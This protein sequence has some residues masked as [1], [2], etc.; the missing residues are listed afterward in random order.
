MPETKAPPLLDPEFL[1]KLEQLELVSRKIFVGRMKGERK[2]K[3]RGSS[4]E[5]AE[6]VTRRSSLAIEMDEVPVT[7]QGP[8]DGLSLRDADIGRRTGVM[9]IAVKRADGRVEFPPSGDEPFAAGDTAVLLGRRSNL[10]LFRSSFQTLT[11]AFA[12]ENR[13]PPIPAGRR[14]GRRGAW[15]GARSRG[16]ARSRAG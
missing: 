6:L 1:H 11:R 4:V 16:R 9:V 8:L 7:S 2:S 3:R 5:F 15:G 10:D 12:F 13:T 14:G